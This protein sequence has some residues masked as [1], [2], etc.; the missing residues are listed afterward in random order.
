MQRN[1]YEV[2]PPKPRRPEVPTKKPE[3]LPPIN[4]PEQPTRINDDDAEEIILPPEYP[5]PEVPTIPPEFPQEP[6]KSIEGG[7][8]IMRL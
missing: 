2:P 4:I 1:P 3:E 5:A 7:V 8:F 6:N